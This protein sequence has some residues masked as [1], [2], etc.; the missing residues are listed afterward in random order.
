MYLRPH[1][2][3]LYY[4]YIC[5]YYLRAHKTKKLCVTFS[6]KC[7]WLNFMHFFGLHKLMSK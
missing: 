3:Y 6:D 1:D 5:N 2:S 4:I 7:G